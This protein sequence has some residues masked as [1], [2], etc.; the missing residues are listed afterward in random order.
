MTRFDQW[1]KMPGRRFGPGA[2]RESFGADPPARRASLIQPEFDA[3]TKGFLSITKMWKIGFIH[4]S[5]LFFRKG[6]AE[7]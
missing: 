2:L 1:A 3:L 5:V 7:R 4:D 6:V